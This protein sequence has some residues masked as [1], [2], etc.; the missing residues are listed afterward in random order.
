MARGAA[1]CPGPRGAGGQPLARSTK[2]A[3]CSRGKK[4]A[5]AAQPIRTE[6]D[7][8]FQLWYFIAI[9]AG[10]FALYWWVTARPGV[11]F[12]TMIIMLI[13]SFFFTAIAGYL[14]GVIGSSNNPISGVTV[15]TL[16]F[17]ALI[18]LAM[19]ATGDEGMVATII[20]AAIVCC[21]AA[22]IVIA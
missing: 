16:L 1:V 10:M 7:F 20:V 18:M 21:S 22:T 4:G 3:S 19:G 11:A 12:I 6:R 8:P 2:P 13:A 5:G 15:A 17:T 14:A 9:G